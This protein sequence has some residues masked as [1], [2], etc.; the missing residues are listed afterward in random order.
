MH[1]GVA[2]GARGSAGAGNVGVMS[3]DEFPEVITARGNGRVT[4]A[5]AVRRRQI[6]RI[7][8]GAYRRAER[9]TTTRYDAARE[10]ARARIYAVHLNLR[11]RHTFSHE[12]AALIWGWRTWNVPSK[13]SLYQDYRASGRAAK[14]VARHRGDLRA[15]DRTAQYGLPVTSRVR[16]A[17]DCAL[18]LHPL[19]A[20]VVLDCALADG[21]QRDEI[22]AEIE[23][24]KDRRGKKAAL[25]LVEIA[26]GGAESAWETWVRYVLVQ[27]GLPT[28]RTQVPV[29]TRV[30]VFRCDVGW[31]KWS[32]VVEFDG[33]VKYQDGAFGNNYSGAQALVDEKVRTDAILEAGTR[34][35][36]AMAGDSP[37]E[38]VRRVVTLLPRELVGAIRPDP[39]LP[40][41]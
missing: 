9:G 4:I 1:R 38:L 23:G 26:D 32:V 41:L 22:V 10:E 3:A 31:P 20:L 17:A 27:A 34:M 19:H 28:P 18:A 15:E 13:T 37:H 29:R 33:R 30:G 35:I 40:A 25:R 5:R 2:V 12:S 24:R 16:T 39:L 36:R 7:R 11:T 6:R 8:R 14:D 21:V